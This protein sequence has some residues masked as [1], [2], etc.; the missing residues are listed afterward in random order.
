MQQPV[1]RPTD[2]RRVHVMALQ[3]RLREM[4]GGWHVHYAEY[5]HYLEMVALDH[6]AALGFPLKETADTLGGL[7]IMRHLDIEYRSSAIAYDNLLLATW[8]ESLRGVRLARASEIR[9]ADRDQVLVI[10]RAEWVWVDTTGRPQRIPRPLVECLTL[11]D[12]SAHV[13]ADPS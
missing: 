7:F 13:S 11:P 5:L 1:E 6:L 10:A 12:V 2:E 3:V 9:H 4:A 8:V